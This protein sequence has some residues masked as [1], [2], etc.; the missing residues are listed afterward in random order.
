M[1]AVIIQGNEAKLV[2]DRILPKL[3]DDQML[4]QPMAVALNPTDWKHIAYRRAKD[5]ALVGCDYSGVVTQVGKAVQKSWRKGD[6]IC[7]CT[8][9]SNLVNPEDGAFAELISVKGDVQVRIPRGLSYEKAATLG[10]GGITVGQGLYQKSL[11][12]RLPNEPI[13]DKEFMLVYGGSTATGALAIQF[14]KFYY[15]KSLGASAVFDYNDPHVGA[16]I[17]AYTDDSLKYAFDT[18]SSGTSI[19]ICA[20][21]LSTQPG[22]RIGILSP[23]KSPRDDVKVTFTAM[24]TMFGKAFQFGPRYMPASLED[25]DFAKM[26]M[27]SQKSCWQSIVTHKERICP[28][29][30][31]G[32]LEGLKH[33]KDGK[34]SGEK[35]VYR[36]DETPDYAS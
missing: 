18:I 27:S 14:A 32:V 7:G 20:E 29:G 10:L 3:Q 30:L 15:V 12:L 24:Y 34:I 4:V 17:R 11:K 23:V 21:A 22:G 36:V 1:R 6:R 19:K 31:A 35:L 2:R 9:G 33:M 26:F 25:L 13:T 16:S 5:G 8:H 28:N